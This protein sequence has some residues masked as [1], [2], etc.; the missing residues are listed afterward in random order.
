MIGRLRD[1]PVPV[2]RY[3][4]TA[5]LLVLGLLLS[6]ATTLTAQVDEGLFERGER[7]AKSGDWQ[8]ALNVWASVPDALIGT[9]RSDPRVGPAFMAMVVTHDVP[10]RFEEA[11]QLYLWGLSGT[12]LESSREDVELEARRIL[13]LLSPRDSVQW[14]PLFDGPV[15]TLALRIG[16]FWLE[17]DPTPETAEN[18]RLVEHWKRIVSAREDYQ[19]NRS[20]VYQTDDRGVIYVKY[21]P[22]DTRS[23]GSLGASEMELKIRIPQDGEARARMRQ[24]DPN[25][26][27][28]LWKYAG[29]HPE[30]FTYY[31][32]GNVRGTG[33]FQWV[34]GPLDLISDAARSLSS[35]SFTPGG[36]RAQHY[37]ELFYYRDLAI[38]GGHFGRRFDELS[39]TWDEFTMR[40][41]VFGG[42]GR[43][44]SSAALES[45]SYRFSEEDKYAPIGVP[46]ISIRSEFEGAAR[47][48]EMVVQAVRVLDPSDQPMVIIQALSAPRLRLAGRER[49]AGL[50][51][52]LRDTEHTLIVRDRQLVEAG[53]VAQ[54]APASLGGISVFHLRHPPQPMHFTVFG[55]VAG[56]RTTEGDTLSLPGQGHAYVE[57]PLRSDPDVFEVSD[58]AVGTPWNIATGATNPLPFPL[59]PGQ[60][61]WTGDALR[62]YLEL[63]HLQMGA[64]GLSRYSL[65]FRLVPLDAAGD[66]RTRTQPITLGFQQ[67]TDS[68]SAKRHFDIGLAGLET[69]FYRLEVDATDRLSGVTVTRVTEIEIIE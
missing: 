48:V 26:Q 1:L 58:L 43:S 63:Y 13:P 17:H 8:A 56:E 6:T 35:A 2:P 57:E 25:P 20:S 16:R 19:Y 14:M 33:P 61:I 67:E 68:R 31:L 65:D 49:R 24:F 40:R 38:L 7:L 59:L 5:C 52:A 47:S 30:E 34:E 32:F 50:Q 45:F 64:E 44:P 4:A 69:G 18:E 23:R 15:E 53:R 46:T 36:V 29:L 9:D 3:G 42:G 22:P 41:N 60:V 10:D 39:N 21:G 37:L 54:M 11:T 12:G 27:F 51:A 62:V 66:V 55:T 28:E